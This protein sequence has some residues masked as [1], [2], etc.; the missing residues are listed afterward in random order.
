MSFFTQLGTESFI[1]EI[2]IPGTEYVAISGGVRI[3][4][5]N[6]C[7][8]IIFYEFLIYIH[9]TF[10]NKR[11]KLRLQNKKAVTTVVGHKVHLRLEEQPPS[12]T[13]PLP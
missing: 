3:V 9:S 1:R 4:S 13:E 11:F 12:S 7:Q 2:H 10:Q 8:P 5:Q 6:G